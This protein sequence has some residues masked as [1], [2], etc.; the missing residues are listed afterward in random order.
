[1]DERII[2]YL[3]FRKAD[4]WEMWF[5]IYTNEKNEKF[6][7]DLRRK[8][9]KYCNP[10][11]KNYLWLTL[12]PDKFLRNMDNTPENLQALETWCTNWFENNPKY[13]GEYSWVVEN[14][15][16][17]DHLHVHAL[18][19]M[20]SSHKH[21]DRLKKSWA[22]HFPNHQL[23]TA[24]NCNTE[25]YKNRDKI[26]KSRWIAGKHT[27]EY[28]YK[29]LDDPMYVQERIDYMDNEKKGCHENLSDTG[30]RGSRGFLT[31]IN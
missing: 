15:S 22:K 2:K 26:P 31:D 8:A 13:Y 5:N 16:E 18:L 28:C 7:K 21:A 25:A 1:M 6:N 11:K 3:K 12:S 19:E 23:L 17:G 30:V 9:N 10:P 27:G 14:G 29:Q 24:V 4:E 20:K